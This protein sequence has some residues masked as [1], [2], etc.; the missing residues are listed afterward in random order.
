MDNLHAIR[1]GQTLHI[2]LMFYFGWQPYAFIYT[3]SVIVFVSL[4]ALI[5]RA[6]LSEDARAAVAIALMESV[7]KG[8]SVA[9]LVLDCLSFV[10]AVAFLRR[11]YWIIKDVN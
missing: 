3:A 10:Y 4:N 5:A 9:I 11:A 1:P 7:V 2:A 6:Q 8:L